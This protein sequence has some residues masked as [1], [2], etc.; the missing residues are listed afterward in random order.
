M[1][2]NKL[3]IHVVAEIGVNFSTLDEAQQMITYAWEAGAFGIKFQLFNEET[4]KDS[5]LKERLSK[6]ILSEQN[7]EDF[8]EHVKRLKLAF[9][10]TPMYLEAIDLAAKY[11]DLIKIRFKDHENQELIDKALDTGKTVLI[12]VPY[13]PIGQ[14]M[15]HPRIKWLYCVSRNGIALYPPEPEDFNLDVAASCD[16]FSSHFSHTL[17]DL[18]YAINRL[19]E[20]AYIEK[21]V[22][23]DYPYDISFSGTKFEKGSYKLSP[24]DEA[25]SI[26]FHDLKALMQNL[27]ILERMKRTRL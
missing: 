8:N 16:G 3:P 14:Y 6:I 21:H 1:K 27:K 13:R 7:I 18:A 10:L 25:V 19:P 5:P 11:A 9:V 17:F 15:Y 24:I 20:E 23:L 22:M 26:N 4:I 2:V 12:S